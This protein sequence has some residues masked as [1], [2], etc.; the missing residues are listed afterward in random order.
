MKSYEFNSLAGCVI[1]RLS[2]ET[3]TLCG[4]YHGEQSGIETDKITP[5]LTVCEAHST[6]VCHGTLALARRHLPFPSSWCD[7]CR[8]RTEQK[9]S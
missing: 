5:W 4:L 2:R 9:D 8:T 7:E 3:G 6:L 1:Q